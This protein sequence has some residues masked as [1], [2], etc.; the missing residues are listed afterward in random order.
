MSTPQATVRSHDDDQTEMRRAQRARVLEAL[1]RAGIAFELHEHPA[2]Y[3]MVEARALERPHPLAQAKNLFV[4]DDKK[5]RYFLM[6]VRDEKRVDLK[7]FRAAH[8]TRRL[9]LAEPEA[10]A[11]LLGLFPGAVSPFGLLNDRAHVV[12]FFV[13]RDFLDEENLIG[14]HP[15]DNT[16]T[17]YL[18]TSDL[19]AFLEAS[20]VRVTLCRFD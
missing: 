5:A 10:L 4:R 2:V 9:S 7:A 13:D 12:E 18:K 6:S 11:T 17:V 15:N 14:L 3:N 20:G 16:A 1:A 19:I 8:G